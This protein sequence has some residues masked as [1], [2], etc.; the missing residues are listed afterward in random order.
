[1]KTKSTNFFMQNKSI[2]RIA[3]L[4]GL[5]LL[6]PL[7]LTIRD[8]GVEGVG[9]NWKLGDFIFAGVMLF[10]TGLALDFTAKKLTNPVYRVI[11]CTAIVVA[12][13]LI[14]VEF[15]VDAVSQALAL[16]F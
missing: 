13:L 4:V 8:G 3:F 12:F 14:W 16:F 7:V 10:G 6:I 5:I 11:A 2:V 1:M 15:A 9:W